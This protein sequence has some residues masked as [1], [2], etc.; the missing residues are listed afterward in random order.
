MNQQPERSLEDVLL[1]IV[2]KKFPERVKDESTHSIEF[3]KEF[4]QDAENIDFFLENIK[5]LYSEGDYPH[6]NLSS[7]LGIIAEILNKNDEPLKSKLFDFTLNLLD[8]SIENL[9]ILGFDIFGES[10]KLF[11]DKRKELYSKIN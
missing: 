10:R 4:L 9:I 3:I 7:I 11:W 6:Y 1:S 2:F 8:S 5:V